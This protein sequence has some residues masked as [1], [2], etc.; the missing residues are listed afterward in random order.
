[1]QT[2]TFFN[3]QA[4]QAILGTV[5]I[6]NHHLVRIADIIEEKHFYEPAHKAIW[7]RIL[8]VVTDST[9]NQITLKEFFENSFEISQVGGSAYLGTLLAESSSIIDIRDY[10]REIINLWQ[11]RELEFLL[12]RAFNDLNSKK[13]DEVSANL[14]NDLLGLMSYCEKRKTQHI[15]EI[16]DQI[17]YKRSHKIEPKIISS[18]FQMLDQKLNGGF[19]SKQLVVIGA[20]TAV[21]K[22][23]FLQEIILKAALAGKKCLLISLEVDSERVTLKFISNVASVAAWK[24]RR[25]ILKPFEFEHV[26]RAEKEIRDAEIYI[27]DSSDLKTSDIEMVVKTQL[28]RQQVDLVAID[29]IQHIKYEN[30]KNLSATMEIS[31]N[32]I[33]LKAMAQKFDVVMLAAAQINRAGTDKPTLAHFE[34]SSAIEKNADVAIII[35]RDELKEEERGN[36]YYSNSGVWIVAKNRDGKTGDIQFKLD[37]EFGRFTEV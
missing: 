20:R 28:E 17:D 36:S 35:H 26:Q 10:A 3:I 19:Y 16:V 11:K 2:T 14:S 4:E 30:D 12:N 31:K 25:N 37:G 32:V 5:I 1:M 23:T 34:G 24:I 8:E 22:T 29:Y 7:G 15:S 27:N 6:G 13:F 21:G 18:G 33:A 9:A